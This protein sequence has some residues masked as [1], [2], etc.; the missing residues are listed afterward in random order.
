M[1]R[2]A[3]DFE[4]AI[5]KEYD[6]R[7]DNIFSLEAKFEPSDLLPRVP[8][9]EL[10]R[11]CECPPFFISSKLRVLERYFNALVKKGIWRKDDEFYVFAEDGDKPEL[12]IRLCDGTSF[13]E[14]AG[15]W[16]VKLV[17]KP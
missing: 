6:L 8:L 2:T 10:G 11:I 17:Q 12:G 1:K 9:I 4:R 7:Y 15:V 16:C 3:R 14:V 13:E 5:R